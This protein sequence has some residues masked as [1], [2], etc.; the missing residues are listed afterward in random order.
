M[1][2]VAKVEEGGK[3]EK[4]EGVVKFGRLGVPRQVEKVGSVGEVE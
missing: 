4:V 2:K 3:V 1:V